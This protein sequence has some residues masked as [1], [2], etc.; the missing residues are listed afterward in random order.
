MNDGSFGITGECNE[1]SADDV[2]LLENHKFKEIQSLFW[3]NSNLNFDNP[4]KL[5]K[6]LDE[7]PK[8]KW[9]KRIHECEDEKV[10]KHLL[11][12]LKNLK[13]FLITS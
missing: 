9:L 12:D 8:E 1:I 2:D 3:R 13:I 5:I 10:L 11:K 6:S 7:R 4:S